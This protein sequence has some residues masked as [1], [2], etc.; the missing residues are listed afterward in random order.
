LTN[1]AA[2]NEFA[3]ALGAE[4]RRG[5]RHHLGR[6]LW[7]ANLLLLAGVVLWIF[8]DPQFPA[9]APLVG[10]SVHEMWGGDTAVARQNSR[11]G[12][13]LPVLW[14][15]LVAVVVTT[16]LL[17]VALFA[18]STTHRRLRSWFAFTMLIAAW[19]TVL[20]AWRE[21]A[22]QG[23]KLRTREMIDAFDPL[24]KSLVDDWP[25]K[26][27]ER[28]GLGSFMA[29]P[30]GRPRMLMMLISETN[31][32]ISAVERYDDGSLGFELRGEENGTW[33]EWHPAGS[34]PKSFVGGLEAEYEFGRTS[35]LGR[36]WYLVRYR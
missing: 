35:P 20:V 24:A 4:P 17:I 1:N 2:T 12:W 8:F 22:W 9:A 10:A 6:G 27:G 3:I 30:Q 36:G 34:T 31:P 29:Y 33:L 16:L 32:Q 19:L 15:V 18:G 26:D 23:Q 11:P 7:I 14:A 5:L 28:P 13:R 21:F 25:I